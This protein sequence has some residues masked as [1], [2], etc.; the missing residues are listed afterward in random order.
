MSLRAP[1]ALTLAVAAMVAACLPDNPSD[2]E[3]TTGGTGTGDTDE[4]TGG[5]TG[6][7][8]ACDGPKC[9]LLLVSQTLDD[10]VDIYDADARSLRGSI[11]LDLKYDASGLQTMNNL[12]DEPY[13]LVLTD[14]D[15]LIALGHW[16]DTD[17]G[18]ILRFPRASLDGSVAVADYFNIGNFIADVQPLTHGRQEG[19][20]LLPHPSGRILVGVF[21]NSLTSSPESWMTPSELLVFDP[22]DLDAADLGSFDLGGL[23]IPCIGGWQLVALDPAVTKVA[24]ACDGSDSVAVLSLP[25][26]FAEASAKDAAAGVTGCGYALPSMNTTQFVSADGGGGFLA[27]Q[28][29]GLATRLS[30]VDY[31]CTAK[32]MPSGPPAGDLA[33]VVTLRQPVLVRSAFD[34]DPVW[35]I[36]AGQPTN[37]VVVARSRNG[38]P[39]LCGV[40]D[41]LELDNTNAPWA[42]ALN[43]A[44]DHLA[45]GAGPT[46]DPFL[47]QGTGQVVWGALDRI[48]LDSCDIALSDAV[49]LNAGRFMPGAPSTWTRAPNVVVVAEIEGDA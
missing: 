24:V 8:L 10:R 40:L 41:G 19:I 42:L 30:H 18:S 22:D 23:D 12:L 11:N 32:G 35:L 14:T 13:D 16:P 1:S 39:E 48:D 37:N 36:A 26:D 31:D 27:V 21:A 5:P 2:T 3:D 34:G 20:F 38:T 7:L 33:Q 49:D 44:R 4:P 6:D 25:A 28:S 47:A 46:G 45:I 9:T 15:L 29:S 43:A 17:K